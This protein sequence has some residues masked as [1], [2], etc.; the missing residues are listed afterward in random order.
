MRNGHTKS[1]GCLKI[2]KSKENM[3][4]KRF[5]LLTVIEATDQRDYKQSIIWK[6]KC[7]CGNITYANT[8]ILNKG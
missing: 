5:G 4:G 7:D 6:C 8:D 2:D 3:I 1:C